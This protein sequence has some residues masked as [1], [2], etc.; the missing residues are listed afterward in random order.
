[1]I[2][3]T[4]R[5][6]SEEKKFVRKLTTIFISLLLFIVFVVYAGLPLFAKF[7]IA[8]TSINQKPVKQNQS[9]NAFLLFPPVLDPLQEAT[10]SGLI[11]VSGTGDKE[12]TIKIV[13]NNVEILKVLSDKDGRFQ[14]AKIKLSE[15]TNTIS[16]TSTLN[17]QESSPSTQLTI[18]FKKS[19]PNLEV[20]NPKDNQ[21]FSDNKEI[22][23][24]G[25]TD[26][27]NR[28]TINERFVIIGW[29]G[30]FKYPVTLTDGDNNLK[31]IASDNAGNQTTVERKVIFIP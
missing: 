13:L 31:I 11:K 23:I 1:M 30:K 16:A 9:E 28:V 15:G 17:N 21:K 3:S 7:I 25:T 2:T 12:A 24:S 29:D 18:I 8:V 10:N 6:R 27:E 5:L 20:E 14:T 4:H 26:P 19:Q 22:T